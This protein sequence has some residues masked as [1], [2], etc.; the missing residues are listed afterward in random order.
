VKVSKNGKTFEITGI[1]DAAIAARFLRQNGFTVLSD[2]QTR[3]GEQRHAPA[4]AG[5]GWTCAKCKTA[6][7]DGQELCGFCDTPRLGG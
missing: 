1:V 4:E 2:S 5:G 3:A 6:N 7:S